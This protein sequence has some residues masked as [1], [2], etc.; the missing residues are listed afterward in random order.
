M[1]AVRRSHDQLIAV[2]VE[3]GGGSLETDA[4]IARD[5]SNDTV[6]F[7]KIAPTSE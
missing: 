1:L 5:D 3:P 4:L 2:G 7:S 6:R